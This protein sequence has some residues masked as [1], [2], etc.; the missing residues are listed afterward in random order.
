MAH[1]GIDEQAV[2]RIWGIDF[3][4]FIDLSGAFNLPDFWD[5][6]KL[7]TFVKPR[8]VSSFIIVPVTCRFVVRNAISAP[9]FVDH[10]F[11]IFC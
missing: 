2:I 10:S 8:P 9:F 6:M 11:L 7:A 5:L 3:T 4:P 1:V